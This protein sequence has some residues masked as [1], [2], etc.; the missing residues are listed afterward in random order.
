M[1]T[2]TTVT[3]P[4]KVSPWLASLPG[5]LD[6]ATTIG[7]LAKLTRADEAI[8]ALSTPAV[9]KAEEAIKAAEVKDTILLSVPVL[10][11]G[12][13]HVQVERVLVLTD[14]AMYRV[15]VPAETDTTGKVEIMCRIPLATILTV[16]GASFGWAIN[17]SVCD[18]EGESVW[19]TWWFEKVRA[20]RSGRFETVYWVSTKGID[21]TLANEWT[22]QTVPLVCSAIRA[23]V[24]IAITGTEGA[25]ERI[26]KLCGDKR[27]V[28]GGPAPAKEMQTMAE[29]EAQAA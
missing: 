20:A 6:T 18:P 3:A 25:A 17:P 5:V 1:S 2:T 29:V 24:R 14:T 10:F 22:A 11:D 21:S 15:Y 9:V 13:Y 26:E 8:S 28:E 16:E 7:D 23:A 4:V 12:R 19:A 27:W